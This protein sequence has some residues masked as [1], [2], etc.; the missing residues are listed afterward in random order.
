MI[1][2]RILLLS[3]ATCVAAAMPA[4]APDAASKPSTTVEAAPN[5]DIGNLIKQ[6]GSDSYRARLEAERA[7]RAVGEPAVAPLQQAAAGGDDAEVQWRARRVL[8]QIQQGGPTELQRRERPS[9][10]PEV[11]DQAPP[12]PAGRG[13]RRPPGKQD[14]AMREQFDS[15]FERLQRDFRIDIPR[16]RFFDDRFFRD[17]QEQM[18]AAPSKS[19]GMS[20]QIGP[21]GAV[22]VEVD[23]KGADGKSGK[24]VYE[25]P[26]MESFHKQHPG[27]L[28]QNG[29]G[30]GLFP[31]GAR[32]FG[33]PI[34]RGWSLDPND[35]APRPWPQVGR[36][37][38]SPPTDI[39]V[40]PSE[41]PPAPPIGKRLGISIRNEIPMAV[42]EYVG[43][44][45]GVGLWVESVQPDSLA[46][47]LELQKDDI[48][49]KIGAHAIASPADV[50]AA[51]ATIKQGEAVEVQFVRKGER[52][53]AKAA[54][55]E[56]SEPAG[57]PAPLQPRANKRGNSIR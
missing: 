49:V 53:T 18:Q 35:M 4:Q 33:G 40:V 30:M 54:K 16:A 15:L 55:T 28:H 12:A 23:E 41:A 6:L 26:D 1:D 38:S 19:Q 44:D 43:L 2:F 9:T 5:Q 17:L 27:V 11:S 29:L 56:D 10:E 14:E 50:Q 22:R 46:A 32:V 31:G 45:D 37:P 57:E 3:A 25:A 34:G 42:R 7:L 13:E 8:R 48:V 39:P 47:A 21:D 20:I 36:V 24:K 51:L 52:K